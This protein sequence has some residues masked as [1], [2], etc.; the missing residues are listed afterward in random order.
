MD[1]SRLIRQVPLFAGL[2]ERALDDL[3]R[4]FERV[5]F[6]AGDSLT[7]Q[8]HAA[9]SACIIESGLAEVVTALPGGG[10]AS[11]AQLESGA[12]LGEMALLDSGVCSATVIAR[13]T[14][15]CHRVTRDGFRMLLAQRVPAVFTIQQRITRTLCQRL[16]VLNARVVAADTEAPALTPA[17]PVAV[18]GGDVTDDFDHRAFL[19]VLPPFRDF[20][21]AD[22]A[23]LCAA[24]RV[25]HLRRGEQLFSQGA[26]S[27][28]CYIVIR[29]ALELTALRGG[30]LHRI[31]ILGPGRLCGVMALI[32][33][34]PH[35]MQAHAR[36]QATLLEM[37]QAA[38][39]T[40]FHGHDRLSLKL[41]HVMHCE[42]LQAL[43][44]TNN[45]LT[46]LISSARVRGA[47]VADLELALRAQDCRVA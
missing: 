14:T 27:N 16:R 3:L 45:H 28:A 29:G 18:A 44:R 10:T 15:V 9:S 17:T 43:A 40:F 37:S 23:A 42:L 36:E 8:G 11:V 21:A 22:I 2:D 30:L 47:P 5:V 7:R 39:D 32:E 34:Q 13:R 33:Q 20:E 46:Q 4:I 24:S 35:S 1:G 31:G 38:F 26:D 12:V 19:P 25:I 6:A 41:Q